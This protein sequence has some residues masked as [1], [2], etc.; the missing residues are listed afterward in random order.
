MKRL[1]FV[2]PKIRQLIVFLDR[3]VHLYCP[4]E[5]FYSVIVLCTHLIEI[6]VSVII[7]NVPISWDLTIL[8]TC[9]LKL[10]YSN[11]KK[12]LIDSC[13]IGTRSIFY[14]C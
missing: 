3:D 14:I 11:T 2:I 1:N 4:Y 9:H 7:H 12:V 6:I 13:V 10:N 8:R 5:K